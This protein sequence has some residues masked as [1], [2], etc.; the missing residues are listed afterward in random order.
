[1]ILDLRFWILDWRTEGMKKLPLLVPGLFSD[2]L[3]SK[4][5]NLKSVVVVMFLTMVVS[6]SFAAEVPKWKEEWARVVEAA[7]KEGQ[8]SLYGGQEINH[9][10]I[11]AAFNKEFPF[12][13]VLSATGRAPDLM[14][15]IVAE[16]R[17]DRY[18]AD[19]MAS[20]PNGPRML[21]LGKALD[22]I[23]PAFILPEV[24]DGSK[25][26]GGKHW[27]ADPENQ[28][29]FM[30][31]GTINSTGLSYNTKM[32]SSGDIKSYW[33]L[34]TPN[35]KGKLLSMDPRGAA[36]P[37]PLLI[38]YHRADVGAEFVRRFYKDT[39]ITLFRDRAQGTNWLASGKFPLCLF[40]RDIDKAAKQGLPVEDIAPDQLKEGASVGGGGSSV[41]V[42]I[43]RAPHPNAAKLFINWY[44]SRQGQIVWQNVMNKREV[45][46]SDSMRIDIPKDDV[47]P[48]AR[49]V[50]G[51]KY[52]VVGFLDPEP[53][54]KLLQEILK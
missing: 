25:W 42:L 30:F 47:L 21:Y 2:N 22:P 5:Q 50:E 28:H 45:E 52:S 48:E 27:Y 35:W 33:E 29:I 4:I 43:N 32:M 53:V 26:Y 14:A 44:L 49:R 51:K 16:R 19:V 46:P 13:K 20:G 36:P 24:T 34:L 17:A 37:T 39:E 12:I 18:L 41:I 54:Q 11:V 31:E 1:M 9:P 3:K 40:C 10:E 7:K 8:I 6:M 38:L 23:A 15:R